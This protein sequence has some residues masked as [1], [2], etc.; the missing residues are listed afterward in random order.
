[1]HLLKSLTLKKGISGT[2]KS[3]GT[4]SAGLG[5]GWLVGTV[6]GIICGLEYQ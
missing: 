3:R 6:S 5:Q 4:A 1:M 2:K